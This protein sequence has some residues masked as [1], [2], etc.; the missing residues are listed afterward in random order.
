MEN[1]LRTASTF[2]D[3]SY[4]FIQHRKIVHVLSQLVNGFQHAFGS[5]LAAFELGVTPA[6]IYRAGSSI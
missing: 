6:V 1:E 4:S 2:W 5:A 3:N